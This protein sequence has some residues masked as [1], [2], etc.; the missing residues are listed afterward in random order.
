MNA[1]GTGGWMRSGGQRY[2]STISRKKDSWCLCIPGFPAAREET[3][4]YL[5]MLCCARVSLH[6]ASVGILGENV[7]TPRPEGGTEDVEGGAG[8]ARDTM[9]C[10]TQPELCK[11]VLR[12]S[13]RSW[14][15][16]YASEIVS[17]SA[18]RPGDACAISLSPSSLLRESRAIFL[19]CA[20]SRAVLLA[21]LSLKWHG[22]DAY[23][24]Q[25][26][27]SRTIHMDAPPFSSSSSLRKF[28][29][30]SRYVLCVCTVS[31]CSESKASHYLETNRHVSSI[32]LHAN[33]KM[34]PKDDDNAAKRPQE[35]AQNQDTSPWTKID[36]TVRQVDEEKVKD[37]TANLDALLVFAG[38]YS[39]ILTAFL[40]ES[41]K[42]LQPDRKEQLLERIA[43][44]TENYSFRGGYLN[45]TYDPSQA[46]PFAAAAS[47]IRVNV[48]WFASLILSL[49][50]ASFGILVRQWLREYLAITSIIPEERVRIRHYRARGLEDWGLFEITAFLPV[51][52]QI[53]FALFFVGLCFFS[54]AV[55]SSIGTT[56]IIGVSGWAVLFIFSILAPAVSARCPYKTT[57]LKAFFAVIRPH[58]RTK[59]IP[60]VSSAIS[61]PTGLFHLAT[62]VSWVVSAKLR[63]VQVC[64]RLR[65]VGGDIASAACAAVGSCIP[66]SHSQVPT[67]GAQQQAA[68]QPTLTVSIP[69]SQQFPE[70]PD[71]MRISVF[72]HV[73]NNTLVEVPEAPYTQEEAEI[74][75]TDHNDLTVFA[76]IDSLFLDDILLSNVR[77]D[78]KRRPRPVSEVLLFVVRLIRSRAG[79]LPRIADVTSEP[80]FP[81]PWS[82]SQR[83]RNTLV[84]ILADSMLHAFPRVSRDQWELLADATGPDQSWSDAFVLIMAL[85]LPQGSVASETVNTLLQQLLSCGTWSPLTIFTNQMEAMSRQDGGWASYCLSKIALA[86]Q[87]S[88][89]TDAAWNLRRIV[90]AIFVGWDEG[91]DDAFLRLLDYV[92]EP[93]PAF[94][95]PT[96]RDILVIFDFACVTLHNFQVTDSTDEYQIENFNNAIG[97]LVGFVFKAI[98]KLEMWLPRVDLRSPHISATRGSDLNNVLTEFLMNP[99]FTYRYLLFL[100]RHSQY[101]SP[102]NAPK[103]FLPD[104]V[105]QMGVIENPA[106]INML[107]ACATFFE[108]CTG[109]EGMDVVDMLRLCTLIYRV[110]TDD[111]REVLDCWHKL[112]HNA[113]A[114]IDAMVNSHHKV[115]S[116]EDST[117][118]V[119]HSDLCSAASS[120]L[121]YQDEDSDDQKWVHRLGITSN[122]TVEEEAEK[123]LEWCNA[124]DVDKAQ[125][126]DKMVNRLRSFVCPA[127]TVY[128]YG[129]KYWRVRRLEDLEKK[130]SENASPNMLSSFVNGS[131]GVAAT[132]LNAEFPKAR[133]RAKSLFETFNS[134]FEYMSGSHW[135]P[136]APHHVPRTDSA[137]AVESRPCVAAPAIT[138]AA[139]TSTSLP[140]EDIHANYENDQA[141]PNT[142]RESSESSHSLPIPSPSRV[143]SGTPESHAAVGLTERTGLAFPLPER[144]SDPSKQRPASVEP[145]RSDALPIDD[146]RIPIGIE[147]PKL[148]YYYVFS[149]VLRYRIIST[150]HGHH[151]AART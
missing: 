24:S 32:A 3:S 84:D 99:Y 142:Q 86:W 150:S 8:D 110:Q 137:A 25:S 67:A 41:Y 125:I 45:S 138:A 147:R 58:V 20:S 139:S 95:A 38:L 7:F 144:S 81:W 49:S 135:D 48:C 74:R 12:S 22:P 33:S 93:N 148:G 39:A 16:Q 57:F 68:S 15:A 94:I 128:E 131:A 118:Q 54:S 130:Q 88:D 21:P 53:A 42:N 106:A 119:G 134:E 123:Y 64:D 113:G 47:D 36:Q 69:D 17:L 40:I 136:L 9:A 140:T 43:G 111:D 56:S 102:D 122:S 92:E 35:T 23:I 104:I 97:R 65:A 121:R 4:L 2:G 133:R 126:P 70:F 85:T 26:I 72:R 60:L 30:R 149:S 145:R 59:V 114:C 82:L 13:A 29:H 44:Q 31:T 19:Q 109:I 103:T 80:K 127:Q 71:Y 76:N 11:A 151:R 50:T 143:Q 55:H 101:L 62:S 37:A 129:W 46:T 98:P 1:R 83:A 105:N 132:M 6:D 90:C 52:L 78:L 61:L 117:C 116:D 112:F 124:F 141:A 100:S 66:L 87:A 10:F 115:D 120:I 108:A 96:P 5:G 89:P 107:N 73:F 34:L 79:I 146:A 18:F 75:S 91:G 51:L 27:D 63:L 28:T 77:E 14:T